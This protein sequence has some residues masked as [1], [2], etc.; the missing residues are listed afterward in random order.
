MNKMYFVVRSKELGH[1]MYFC[2]GRHGLGTDWTFNIADAITWTT[3]HMP[4]MVADVQKSREVSI[5]SMT[6]KEYFKRKLQG[7]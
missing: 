2:H 7:K 6:T 4:K 5:V 1:E 3:D